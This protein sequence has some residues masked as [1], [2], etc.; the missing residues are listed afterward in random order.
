MH[1]GDRAYRSE[2]FLEQLSRQLEP[3]SPTIREEQDHCNWP[4]TIWGGNKAGHLPTWLCVQLH[5]PGRELYAPSPLH[6]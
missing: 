4:N 1:R 3:V 2:K 6:Q 5:A